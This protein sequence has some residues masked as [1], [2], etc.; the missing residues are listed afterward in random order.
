MPAEEHVRLPDGL[1]LLDSLPSSMLALGIAYQS[2]PAGDALAG[3]AA[4]NTASPLNRSR[5][6]LGSYAR[7]ATRSAIS[8]R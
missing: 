7:R 4:E 5:R 3:A 2:L 1:F 8:A 6:M